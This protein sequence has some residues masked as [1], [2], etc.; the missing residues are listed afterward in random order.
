[1]RTADDV[2][3]IKPLSFFLPLTFFYVQLLCHHQLACSLY[4]LQLYMDVHFFDRRLDQWN[5][6]QLTLHVSLV[7]AS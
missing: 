1:M 3:D 2:G 5:I 6:R 4:T 7:Y